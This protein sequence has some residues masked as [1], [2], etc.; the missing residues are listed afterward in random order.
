MISVGIEDWIAVGDGKGCATV[1]KV[2]N[3]ADSPKVDFA[4]SWSAEM[5]RHLL[6]INFC[7][8]LGHRLKN[9]FIIGL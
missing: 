8:S 3:H 6:G 1:V 2:V 9:Y 4:F 7:R 5:D